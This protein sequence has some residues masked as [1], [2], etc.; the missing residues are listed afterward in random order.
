MVETPTVLDRPVDSAI[1]NIRVLQAYVDELLVHMVHPAD[2]TVVVVLRG[3]SGEL[4]RSEL[5][6][7]GVEQLFPILDTAITSESVFHMFETRLHLQGKDTESDAEDC[8]DQSEE[9]ESFEQYRDVWQGLLGLGV[10]TIMILLRGR[11][12][13]GF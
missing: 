1:A 13:S 10:L 5:V 7:P 12:G 9:Q 8:K 3:M 4:C 2:E 11:G 6:E